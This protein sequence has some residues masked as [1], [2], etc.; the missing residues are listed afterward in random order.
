MKKLLSIVLAALMLSQ[1]ATA[2]MAD[3]PAAG[4]TLA[5]GSHLVLAD[6][7]YIDGIDGTIT[8]GE[9]KANFAGD[10]SVADKDDDAA[11]ATDDVV[12]DY[13]ALIYGDVNRDGKV[14]LSDVS[15][16]LQKLAGWDVDVNSDAADVDKS[17]DADLLDLTKM[18]K[19]V[20][21]WDDISLGNVRMVFENAAVTAE[22]EDPT[23]KLS[24]TNMMN[25]IGK[26]E[27]Q[28]TG[29]NSFKIKLARNE[30]DSCQALLWSETA[31]EGMTAEVTDFV[32]EYGDAVIKPRFEWVVYEPTVAVFTELLDGNDGMYGDP[33]RT[34]TDDMPEVLLPMADTFEMKE[35]VLQHFVITVKAE[36]D[37]PAGMYKAQLIFRDAGGKEVKKADVYAYVWDFT[38]PDAPYSASLF[39]GN[40]TV[41]NY[42]FLLENN[43]SDYVLP[44]E[45][46][47]PRADAY[48][49]DP[50]VT[51]FAIAGCTAGPNG[52][53]GTAMYAN[54]MSKTPEQTIANY[55]KVAANPEWFK[56]GLFYYT[57]EPSGD[58]L[59]VIKNTYE[60]VTELLGTTNIRNM[61]PIA[62]HGYLNQD[63]QT[64]NIDNIEYMD[65]YIN[66]WCP[67]A[68][69][70]HL[71]EEKGKWTPRYAYNKYGN[72][73]DR[74]AALK[75]KGEEIW[76]Y[77]CVDP[78]VPYAN[79]FTCYQ[80]VI[81]RMVSWQ[82]YFNDV[83]GSLYYRT[84]GGTITKYKFDI[85][86][87]D[88]VLQYRANIW[89]REGYGPSWRLYQVR[90]GFDDFDYL[91]MA[92]EYYGRD[93][94]ME[95]VRKVT[96][97][98][99]RFTEDYRVMDACRDE[100]AE[101]ILAAQGK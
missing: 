53:Y 58:G 67:Q 33:Q 54:I 32:Y 92:E 68:H 48:M 34:Y 22:D 27:L 14:N 71:L 78:Q 76:W 99:R 70:Y 98:M 96:T 42:E 37:S 20:A 39:S 64:K 52:E 85:G 83:D 46:T 90:D 45:I 65:P 1:V 31:R 19:K 75:A 9:L 28:H 56:K 61:T 11:V 25:K 35:G 84:F 72:Y 8:V 69:A 82:Q 29:E 87:G 40:Q 100:L 94:V 79:Y 60:Y 74:A 12:G 7:G 63:Y 47:D 80:G 13:K 97:G 93:A 38:L 15:A 18:L 89:G 4:L 16:M 77:V 36:K 41:E 10:V 3:E 95:I 26:N 24:F 44:Y 86:N 88:G 73:A 17:D 30:Y 91:S 21:G 2:V 23:L 49:S 51:A 6:N 66:V 81:N 55:N 101:M 5:E 57:D 43:L 50:R 62:G 59:L